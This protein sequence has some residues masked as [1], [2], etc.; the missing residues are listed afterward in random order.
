MYEEFRQ[1][2]EKNEIVTCSIVMFENICVYIHTYKIQKKFAKKISGS[3][4]RRKIK[5][6]GESRPK[7]HIHS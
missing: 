7:V 2:M 4:I 1:T 3:Y 5:K 6:M